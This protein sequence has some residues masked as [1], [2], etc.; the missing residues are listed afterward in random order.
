MLRDSNGLTV[1]PLGLGTWRMGERP[2]QRRAEIEAIQTGIDLGL[3]LIDTAEMYG[4]GGA[5]SVVGEAIAGRRDGLTLVSKVLPS[6][7]SYQG[8]IK[9]CDRSRKRLG[10][11]RIDVYLLHW[12]SS[13]P[14]SETIDAFETLRDQGAIGAWGVS[15]FDPREM[16]GLLAQ[17]GA[18]A[19]V[20]NQVYYSLGARG[21]EYDLLPLMREQAHPM[22]AMAYCPLDQG[23]LAWHEALLPIAER[24]QATCAQV[25]LAWLLS[26]PDV[27]V[28]PKSSSA[29]RVTENAGAR[30]LQLNAEDIAALD[31]A[32]PPPDRA[33]P[34]RIV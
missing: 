26:Q 2:G 16:Q 32:F 12:M 11:D 18:Q 21:I 8:V 30:A 3:T 29:A 19:C 5:E 25:A 1:P 22:P 10:V 17:S 7:A 20:T 4:N 24:H 13:T 33:E 27:I 23:E 14:L 9:A 34:L 31:A 28:I 6:N 15:N